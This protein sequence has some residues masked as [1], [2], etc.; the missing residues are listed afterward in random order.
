[1]FLLKK[2]LN[3]KNKIL[4]MNL[5]FIRNKYTFDLSLLTLFLVFFL[6][7]LKQIKLFSITVTSNKAIPLFFLCFYYLKKIFILIKLG[8]INAVFVLIITLF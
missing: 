4:F 8:S 6:I 7:S 5:K 2:Y 3:L 1:M